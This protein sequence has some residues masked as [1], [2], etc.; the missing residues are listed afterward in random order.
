[1]PGE[2][3]HVLR[4]VLA[5]LLVVLVAAAG[6]AAPAVRQVLLL[7]SFD[8]GGSLVFDR[9]TADFREAL[10]ERAAGPVTVTQFVLAPAG[11]ADAPE[12]PILDFLLTAFVQRSRPDLVVTVGGPA[13]AFARKYRQR[14]FPGVPFLYG[15]TEQRFLR[16]DPLDGNETAVMTSIDYTQLV[17]DIL[18]VL[19]ETSR[20]FMVMGAGPLGKFWHGELEQ[21]FQRFRDRLTFDWSDDL[22]YAQMLQRAADLPPRSA[23]LYVT[24]GTDAQGGWQGTTRALADL[25]A[26]ANAPLFG[27]HSLWLGLGI[28]GG[29]LMVNEATGGIAADAAIRILNGES[30]GSIRMPPRPL[31]PPAFDWRQLRRWNIPEARL[32]PASLVRFRGPSLWVD[33]RRE[34]LGVLAALAVQSLLIFGL[35][36]QRRAR[37]RAEVD[38]RRSLALAA[39]ANRRVTMSALTASIAHELSQPLGS[40]LSNTRAAELL[41][42]ANRA[43]PDVLREI[44]SDI[45]SEN[46][47][48][49]QIIERHRTMLR[50]HQ[51]DKKPADLH[52]IVRE[53]VALVGHDMS[54]R[55]IQVTV[56]LPSEPCPI[57]ADQVLLQ[58]VLVNLLMNAMDAMADTPPDRRR[59][60][61]RGDV[62]ADRGAISVCDG[63]TGLTPGVDGRLFE[64]F[65]TTKTTG[66]GIGLTIARMIVEAHDGAIEAHNNP[67]GGATFTVTLPR[68]DAP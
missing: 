34:V 6:D 36:Y 17:D 3:K 57:D 68:T 14:L 45:G 18:Q 42:A 27:V 40:I 63:G 59:I 21:N 33:Y 13:A 9:F 66:I 60:V 38:S 31:G 1:M 22:T 4:G 47:R 12:Q 50:S 41:L 10:D 51:L 29:T 43:T 26:Q 28:V 25:S 48:A 35:L 56:D 53:S 30:P 61:V 15:A 55:R 37:R 19:P 32:P 39:D 52:A 23:I 16:D 24:S 20:V 2:Q 8:R 62:S 11:F 64:P 54:T 67:D 46:V 49:S 65:V 5:G 7:Q 58:Q 44:L